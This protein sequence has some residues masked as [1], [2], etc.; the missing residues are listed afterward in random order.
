[1]AKR[2]SQ[3]LLVAVI[4]L[5]LFS[6]MMSILAML[7]WNRSG[8]LTQEVETAQNNRMEVEKVSKIRSAE[9][10]ELK[11]MLG[12]PADEKIETIQTQFE[13]DKKLYGESV[14][15]ENRNY[16]ELPIY[17]SN[18]VRAL[19]EQL[20]QANEKELQLKKEK[21][22]SVAAEAARTEQAESQLK[23]V[24]DDMQSELAKFKK[25]KDEWTTITNQLQ[26]DRR[27]LDDELKEVK[28]TLE[29]K[30]AQQA[31][32]VKSLTLKNRNLARELDEFKDQSFEDPDGKILW[33]NQRGRAVQLNLGRADGLQRQVSFSVFDVDENN[34]AKAKK[35]GSIEVT[36]ILGDHRSEAR[37]T[38]DNYSNP[39]VPGDVVYS[40]IWQPGNSMRFALAGYMDIDGDGESDRRLV[41]NIIEMNGGTIDAEVTGKSGRTGELSIRTRFLV[42]GDKPRI[43]ENA[44]AGASE[45]EIAAY[46]AIIE[47]A[48]QLGVQQIPVDRLLS[49]LGYRGSAK[50]VALG[51]NA[52]E[53]D[54]DGSRTPKKD[55]RFRTRRPP[56]SRSPY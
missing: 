39:V 13:D 20:N 52:R 11:Q 32:E 17:L 28:Q 42:L 33:V 19:N 36:R 49:D 41:K 26:S 16:R 1:M 43:T 38:D 31:G 2:E 8:R 51:E 25:E 10:Q 3:G 29:D 56:N 24:M 4:L 44:A 23:K 22:Q 55:S 5:V 21:D 47:E 54:F 18:A 6:L 50:T 7:F 35:K 14:P 27:K 40:P 9:N 15:E 48:E 46:S 30:I 45:A 34:L 37:I 53:E 12:Y